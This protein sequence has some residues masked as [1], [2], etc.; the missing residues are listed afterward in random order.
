[1]SETEYKIPQEAWLTLLSEDTKRAMKEFELA[2][3]TF[4]ADVV[5]GYKRMIDQAT[6]GEDRCCIDTNPRPYG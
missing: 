5:E 2:N 6:Y 1:M 4:L 3:P